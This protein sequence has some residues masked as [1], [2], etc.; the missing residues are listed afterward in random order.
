MLIALTNTGKRFYKEWVFKSLNF[1]FHPG[2]HYAITGKNG[3]GKSTLM[4]MLA[5]YLMPSAGEVKWQLDGKSVE[6]E[7]LFNHISLA[8][9]YLELIEEFTL[10]E[11]VK[12]HQRFKPFLPGFDPTSLIGLSGLQGSRNKLI[13]H[14]SSG[15]RQRL[16]LLF[17]IMSNT[18]V[19]LLDEPCSNLDKEAVEWYQ[20]LKEAFGKGR[21]FIV[22]SNHN[23]NEYPNSESILS[24]V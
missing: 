3:S 24:L 14:F 2:F 23:P 11:S 6:P 16:K 21:L 5:G 12:F 8:S 1:Q 7:L 4:L 13:K 19:V 15:M 17:A 9:P 18:T 22:S 20:Q 10:L